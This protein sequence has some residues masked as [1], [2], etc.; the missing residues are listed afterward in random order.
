MLALRGNIQPV[1][2]RF[3]PS[4]NY[5]RSGVARGSTPL[6][7]YA[8][9]WRCRIHRLGGTLKVG[10]TLK[11]SSSA[12]EILM[13]WNCTPAVF[14]FGVLMKV[15]FFFPTHCWSVST[16]WRGKWWSLGGGGGVSSAGENTYWQGNGFLHTKA[17]LSIEWPTICSLFHHFYHSSNRWGACSCTEQRFYILFYF[18]HSVRNWKKL[19]ECELCLVFVCQRIFKSIHNSFPPPTPPF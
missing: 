15:F 8:F 1:C 3:L 11:Y 7:G 5:A 17:A 14:C 6:M 18:F 4:Y 12:V 2:F 10:F 13:E 19:T 9:L 16:L